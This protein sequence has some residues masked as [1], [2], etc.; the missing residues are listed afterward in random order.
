MSGWTPG[1]WRVPRG[2]QRRVTSHHG[3]V[4]CNAVLRNQG[5][6][7]AK[8][9][10]KSEHEAEANAALIAA[11]PDLY[12]SLAAIVMHYGDRGN[13]PGHAHDRTGIW[14]DDNEPSKAGKPCQ[15]CAE[16]NSAL[17]ALAKARGEFTP[18][19]PDTE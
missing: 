12:E 1:P 17:A 3:V 2:A 18:F 6:P 7:K 15:W 13:A 5:G 8:T 11:A 14:D 16:W 4:I 9:C 19:H 10:L